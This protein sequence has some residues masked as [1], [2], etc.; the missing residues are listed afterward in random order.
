VDLA[1]GPPTR[2][3]VTLNDGSAVDVWADSVEGLSGPEDDRDY[4]FGSLM[5]IDEAE[6]SGFEILARTPSNPRRVE[7]A[8][9]RFPRAVVRAVGSDRAQETPTS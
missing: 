1:S 9:A 2:W 7:V 5:D 6:Q 8:V 3:I 4:T